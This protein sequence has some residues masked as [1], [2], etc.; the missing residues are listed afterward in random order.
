MGCVRLI[1]NAAHS[2]WR[3]A[4]GLG[5]SATS[6]WTKENL[7]GPVIAPFS[8]VSVTLRRWV[9]H[10]YSYAYHTELDKSDKIEGRCFTTKRV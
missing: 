4:Q 3:R 9:S 1:S 7:P 5:L 10:L 6:P 8:D 2:R